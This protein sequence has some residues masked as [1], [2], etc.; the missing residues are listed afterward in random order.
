VDA[1]VA[2]AFAIGV[3]EPDG[4]GI[5][6]GGGMVIY[7]NKRKE[8]YFINYYAKASEQGSAAGYSGSK[9]V[10]SGKSVCIPGT[11]AGLTLAH[12]KFG[13]LPMETI[14]APAIRLAAEG[15]KVDGVLAQIL[16]DN[17]E[18]IYSDENTLGIFTTE[19]FPYMEGDVIKQE[20]LAETLKIIAREGRKG[21]YE[22]PLAESMVNGLRERGGTQT[23]HDF[24]NY[25]ALLSE[26]LMGNY[27]GYGV[28]TATP[29]QSGLSLIEALNMLENHPLGEGAHY[30]LSAKTLHL[31]AE[32]ERQVYADRFRYL[33]DPAMV[34]IP[35][36][37]LTSKAY[38]MEQFEQINPLKLDPA[39]YDA[40]EP[41]DPYP[42]L[43][44][45][46]RHA[47][48]PVDPHSYH[49]Y[50]G[51]HTTHLSVIDREGNCVS[52][53]QTLGLFF[54]SGQTVN[55]VIFNC[56]MTNFSYRDQ[57]SP[58]LYNNGK[59]PRSSIMPTILLKGDEPFLVIGSPGAA[60]I[61]STMIEVVVNVVDYGMDAEQA[62]LAPRF[63]CSHQTDE[64]HLEGGIGPEVRT[65]LESMGHILR[66]YQDI[67][68]YFGGVQMILVDPDDHLF[69]GSADKRRGG[70]AEGY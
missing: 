64:L 30:S 28:L 18:S 4:S 57:E 19:G 6:G 54:G 26:P 7:L 49:E 53:T 15:F 39:P 8:S 13:S 12:E 55:G 17:V 56:A 27:R 2:A 46:L 21:F 36:D 59:I 5:G 29:P 68:L 65:Q 70:S 63:F 47:M 67:D 66:V 1:A 33:G 34:S 48:E 20:D 9:D 23:L 31:L 22:G 41:G 44:Q 32:T 10:L 50:D 69:Y 35:L 38:G 45:S 60:R 25:E 51:G 43:E 58:N 52:L 42:Y 14:L 3:V 11:V 62:N 61:I 16:L 40:V 24:A 37:G